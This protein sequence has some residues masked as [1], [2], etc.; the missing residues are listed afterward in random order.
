[1][2]KAELTWSKNLT[3]SLLIRASGMSGAPKHGFSTMK[4][5]GSITGLSN[6]AGMPFRTVLRLRKKLNETKDPAK[7]IEKFEKPLKSCWKSRNTNSNLA[8][9]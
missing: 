6:T 2:R 7:V 1:M 8:I 5:Y 3:D 9:K 4:T